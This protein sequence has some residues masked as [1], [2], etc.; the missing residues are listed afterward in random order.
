M[1]LIVINDKYIINNVIIIYSI[2][3]NLDLDI[4]NYELNDILE[5]FK[6]PSDFEVIGIGIRAN[7][8]DH[9]SHLPSILLRNF[10]IGIKLI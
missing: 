1:N 4:N 9:L 8:V 5:L 10:H 2:M 6:I 7:F 3:D